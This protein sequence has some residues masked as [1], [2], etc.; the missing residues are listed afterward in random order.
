M[1]RPFGYV[2]YGQ[3]QAYEQPKG[4]TPAERY[5][6]CHP[7]GEGVERHDPYDE[8]RLAGVEAA[9]AA[10]TAGCSS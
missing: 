6:Y 7:F 4:L 2:V 10:K 8:Q 5:P 3:S 9:H 1:A